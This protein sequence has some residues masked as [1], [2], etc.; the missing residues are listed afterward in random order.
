MGITI[1]DLGDAVHGAEGFLGI[2]N[3]LTGSRSVVLQVD[4]RTKVTLEFLSESSVHGGVHEPPPM[5]IPPGHAGIFSAQSTGFATGVDG[6]ATY[7]ASGFNVTLHW[8]LAFIGGT[9]QAR[10]DLNGEMAA[11]YT[12]RAFAGVGTQKVIMHF[13]IGASVIDHVGIAEKKQ[14]LHDGGLS[15][16]SPLGPERANADNVG[17]SQEFEHGVIYWS[18]TTTAH[19]VWGAILRKWTELGREDYGYPTSD[20]MDELGGKV[21]HFQQVHPGEVFRGSIYWSL[22]SGA[23]EVRGAIREAWWGHGG[24]SGFLGYPIGDEEDLPGGAGRLSRFEHGS[25]SWNPTTGTIVIPS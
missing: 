9:N 8:H 10:T 20:E 19:A 21:S 23:H 12:K 25:I 17:R 2:L 14:A 24:A 16:G 11:R 22:P 4:N 15:L 18:P 5:R 6:Q 3:D 1:A 13:E 7:A